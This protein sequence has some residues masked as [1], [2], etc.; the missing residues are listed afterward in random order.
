VRRKDKGRRLFVTDAMTKHGR[1]AGVYWAFVSG[2][3]DDLGPDAKEKHYAFKGKDVEWWFE[4]MLIPKCK[5]L[6]GN[7]IA[8]VID[9]ATTH[10]RNISG[11]TISKVKKNKKSIVDYLTARGVIANMTMTK[12]QLVELLHNN[13]DTT[14]KLE[15]ICARHK[16]ELLLLPIMHPELNPIEKAWA[17][18][19]NKVA[20]LYKRERK[21]AEVKEQFVQYLEEGCERYA[22][23]W[24]WSAINTGIL[25]LK[26]D[27]K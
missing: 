18:A 11:L 3:V 26:K 1:V 4:H 14:T 27:I 13:W 12:A 25:Y 16:V 15:E 5:E 22:E 23:K 20:A 21:F 9:N 10:T 7:H 17:Y 24:Y 19:K 8:I 2:Q 6:Y